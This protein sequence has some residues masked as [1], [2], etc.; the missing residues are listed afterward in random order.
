M[1]TGTK[2]QNN[3]VPILIIAGLFF[4]FGFV[5][6]ING[7]LIPFMKTINELTDA[8][9]Y[10]VASASYISF[11]VMALPASYI[12]SKIGYR[13]GMSLGLFIMAIGALLFIP[14]AEARTYWV[15]LTGIFIQG[16]GMT[17]LQT[18]SNP[19]ITILGPIES[20]A[21]RI[22]IM[23]IANKTAGA[24]GSLIFGAIL[25]SGIDAVQEQLARASDDEKTILLDTMADSVF[26]PYIIMASVLAILGI[27]IRKAPLPH[28]EPVESEDDIHGDTS[29]KTIF[30]FPHLWLGV[31]ALFVYVGAEVIAGDTII[32][33]GISLG[34]PGTDAKFF[35]TYTLM[36]MVGTYALGVFLIPKYVNQ[37]TALIVSAILGMVFSILILST[38]GIT[39]VLFVAALGIANALV[40]PAIWPLTLDGL[41]KHTKTASALLIMAI[42]GG[43]I[44]PPLYGRIVDSTKLELMS[45]GMDSSEALAIASTESYWILI[46][47]YAM[48][49]FFA[50]WGH[51]IKSKPTKD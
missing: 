50:V 45:S 44:I 25:L 16:I 22:A 30:Q 51:K 1:T 21:K 35:T 4:I 6:W 43:A 37:K 15:F 12:L 34:M 49:L 27:L 13:K 48:I 33:Y 20:G 7:A 31:L 23:G 39:S 9:S 32:S 18:A 14:A 26:M 10:L 38:S 46:P 36:A 8:Q 11:V 29:K 42:A 3:L 47:C 17:L 24:L 40:W 41:G 19:Y 28:V 2:P 5:T